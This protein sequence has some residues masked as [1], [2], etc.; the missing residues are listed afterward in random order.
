MNESLY[1][2]EERKIELEKEL[3]KEIYDLQNN[4][5]CKEKFIFCIKKYNF[6]DFYYLFTTYIGTLEVKRALPT[7][8]KDEIIK[9]E[10][11]IQN[12]NDYEYYKTPKTINHKIY[13]IKK[14]EKYKS[15]SLKKITKKNY[16]KK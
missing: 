6:M 1:I 10:I 5:I 16:N 12:E 13:D 7:D 3:A 14:I 2:T 9:Q 11:L 15:M 4:I 8:W